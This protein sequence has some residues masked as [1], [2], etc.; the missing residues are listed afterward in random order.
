MLPTGPESTPSANW[1]TGSL[2]QRQGN[3]K[4]AAWFPD[5]CYP[6]A[7]PFIGPPPPKRPPWPPTRRI[8]KLDSGAVEMGKIPIVEIPLMVEAR[9]RGQPP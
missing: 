9:A 6:P 3:L 8:T 1:I 7:L 4:A 2:V 5:G